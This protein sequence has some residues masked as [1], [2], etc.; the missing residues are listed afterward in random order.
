MPTTGV[1]NVWTH[2]QRHVLWQ[3]KGDS[4]LEWP[5]RVAV[6][7][8]IFKDALHACGLKD[9]INVRQLQAQCA[10]AE[11]P[12][13][14]WQLVTQPPAT[15]EE[16]QLRGDLKTK[17]DALIAAT[18]LSSPLRTPNTPRKRTEANVAMQG[19]GDDDEDNGDDDP[20]ARST[21]KRRRV[22]DL[23]Q[24]E[25]GIAVPVDVIT[26]RRARAPPMPSSSS[27]P[28][29][30]STMLRRKARE[31]RA[32]VVFTRYN[33]TQLML[34]Q[35]EA[36]EAVLD[37]VAPLEE[38]AK[39]ELPELL[40]RY[41]DSKSQGLNSPER[42]VCGRFMNAKTRPRSAPMAA[43][44]EWNDVINHLD[45]HKEST[46]FISTS[47]MLVWVLHKAMKCYELGERTG[48]IS[49]ID[50]MHVA[51]EEAF[52]VPPLHDATRKQRPYTNG[53]FQYRGSSEHLIWHE[54]RQSAIRHTFSVQDFVRLARAPS[55]D[56][57]LRLGTVAKGIVNKV[58]VSKQLK[59]EKLPLADHVDA[60]AQVVLFVDPKF[61]EFDKMWCICYEVIRGW[62]IKVDRRDSGQW[63][64]FARAFAH[65]ICRRRDK[66]TSLADQAVMMEAFRRAVKWSL[67][68]ANTRYKPQEIE[69][70][71][72]R[73]SKAGLQDD[74]CIVWEELWKAQNALD[75]VQ[76][77]GRQGYVLLTAGDEDGQAEGGAAEED[78][79]DEGFE[80]AEVIEVKAP[81]VR[82]SARRTSA[83]EQAMAEEI[84]Y[85]S[86]SDDE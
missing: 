41:W 67:G 56:K 35:V 14:S 53:G 44:L 59:D 80:S 51:R 12:R 65:S 25:Y 49:V 57:F 83:Y 72:R 70:M 76:R 86:D 33:G 19:S 64:E 61:T 28:S 48:S 46:P 2:E 38:L 55:L 5:Q 7:N 21:R 82:T 74:A 22:L 45:H 79:M 24:Y 20:P 42:F 81:L 13:K 17:V 1:H 3:L 75:R 40:F 77:Q 60:I 11:L 68:V 18:T 10:K 29:R 30:L 27:S 63:A 62:E 32:K 15:I 71:E 8:D 47:S 43:D 26:P 9:G 34:T 4:R 84:V 23:A 36:D 6:F 31:E 85:A 78:E 73:A 58:S 66:P 37:L 69:M 50:T 39:P 16:E 52:F 54:I